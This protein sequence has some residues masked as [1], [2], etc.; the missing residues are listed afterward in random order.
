MN[1]IIYMKSQIDFQLNYREDFLK[2]D[3]EETK[4]TIMENT[5]AMYGD[6]GTCDTKY[7]DEHNI[8]YYQNKLL[9]G[10]GCII[11][12]K[13]N[14]LLDIKRKLK[15]DGKAFSDKFSNAL[16][17]YLK[18]K[19]LNSVRCDNNDVLIDNFKVAS[20][21]EV[22]LPT[23]LQYLCYQISIN[24]DI[25]T[26]KHACTKP[27]FKVPKALSEYGITTEEMITFCENYWTKN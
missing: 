21:A 1:N 24:Q 4:I 11:A 18:N 19:G 8:P 9:T 10:T 20:A 22:T 15:D 23:G 26:I 5:E 12:V 6:D 25:E 17:E 27:M 2:S 14:L 7:C 13:G 3:K 16:C